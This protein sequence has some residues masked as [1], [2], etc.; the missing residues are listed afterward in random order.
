MLQSFMGR[1]DSGLLKLVDVTAPEFGAVGD[2]VVRVV[3]AVGSVQVR[4]SIAY[5]TST[6]TWVE[7][8]VLIPTSV[9]VNT[10]NTT[11]NR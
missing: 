10:S 3:A 11:Y 5:E 7:K 8:Q 1:I 6:N 2:G 4:G 9:T